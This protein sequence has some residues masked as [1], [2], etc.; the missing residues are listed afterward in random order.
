MLRSNRNAPRGA[1]CAYGCCTDRLSR[2]AERRIAR[3]REARAW[4]REVSA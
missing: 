4:R 2:K 1:R 3:R